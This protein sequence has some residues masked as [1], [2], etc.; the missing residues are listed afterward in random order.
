MIVPEEEASADHLMSGWQS[1]FHRLL[2]HEMHLSFTGL[3]H[4]GR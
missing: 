3:G 2:C 1:S 4:G